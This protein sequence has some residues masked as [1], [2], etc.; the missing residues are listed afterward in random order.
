VKRSPGALDLLVPPALFGEA[1][2][3]RIR[4]ARGDFSQLDQIWPMAAEPLREIRRRFN[5]CRCASP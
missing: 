2:V 1:L 4:P 5:G 3:R